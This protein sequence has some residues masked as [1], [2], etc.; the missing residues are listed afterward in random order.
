M[1]G[2]D[3]ST[4][5]WRHPN[6]TICFTLRK[7][8]DV[9]DD[10]DCRFKNFKK[11]IRSFSPSLFSSLTRE[12]ERERERERRKEKSRV[13]RVPRFITFPIEKGGEIDSAPKNEL[14]KG[15]K[16]R[17]ICSSSS[18]VAA[19]TAEAAEKED[20]QV[21]P[22]CVSN[23]P[24]MEYR[25]KIVFFLLLE[26]TYEFCKLFNQTFGKKKNYLFLLAHAWSSLE[27]KR[28][29]WLAR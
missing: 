12:R 21:D 15:G 6:D 28:S 23:D 18:S 7:D 4:E 17:L 13:V 9:D 3:E 29:H 2:T 5:L 22:F 16:N 11:P 20:Q 24:R 8:S 14:L 25:Q 10:D 1:E 19:A 27:I 26:K